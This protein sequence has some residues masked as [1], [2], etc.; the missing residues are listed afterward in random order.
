MKVSAVLKNLAKENVELRSKTLLLISL[1]LIPGLAFARPINFIVDDE[2]GRDNVS[3]NS[4]APIELIVGRTTKVKGKITIDDSLDLKKIPP[5]VS[6]EVDLASIDT[7]IPLRNEHMRDNFLETKKYPKAVFNVSGIAA[8][9][10]DKL[11]NGNSLTINAK[12]DFTLHGVKVKKDIPVKVTY[13]KESEATHTRFPKGNVIKIQ[14]TFDVPLEQHK[15]KRPEAIF[16]KLANTVKV[17]IDAY[18][19]SEEK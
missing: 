13:L 9:S 7:G 15:I 4:D 8:N 1:L 18:A 6:F 16:Q 19:V 3:F 12:G 11:T 2:L 14:S 17:T 5:K 10:Q